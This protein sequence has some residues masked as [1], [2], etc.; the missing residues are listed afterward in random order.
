[1]VRGMKKTD[2][3]EDATLLPM[4]VWGLVL[5]VVGAVGVMMFV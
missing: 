4:L 2:E 1:M 3:R 5:V